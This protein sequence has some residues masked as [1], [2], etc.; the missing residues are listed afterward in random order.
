MRLAANNFG[1]DQAK[2]VLVG[3]YWAGEVARV[4]FLGIFLCD[5]GKKEDGALVLVGDFSLFVYD[6]GVV[7][8]PVGGCRNRLA[9]REL[10]SLDAADD[11]V[12]VAADASR[13][14]ERE[15]ELVLW[16]DDENSADGERERLGV[17]GPGINHA[18]HGGDLA[19]GVANDREFDFDLVVAVSNDVLQPVF[20]RFDGVDGEG[21]DQAVHGGQFVVLESEAANF[22]SA[23]RGK[24]GRMRKQDRPLPFLPFVEIHRSLRRFGMEVWANVAETK[25]GIG[26]LLGVKGHVGFGSG[27]HL[28]AHLET[29]EEGC[30]LVVFI[31]LVTRK[32]Q[33][34]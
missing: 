16:I 25:T 32:V 15:H 20:V 5:G 27:R 28:G 33:L 10:E 18:V 34:L 31:L 23:N 12:H 4:V 22:S 13:V 1:F 8:G 3:R 17:A 6:G 21:R 2:I 30:E 26:R 7:V 14:V 19:V 24:I 11:F 9:V 29:G